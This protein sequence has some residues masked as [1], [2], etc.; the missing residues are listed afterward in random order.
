MLSGSSGI[1]PAIKSLQPSTQKGAMPIAPE[2]IAAQ[3]EVET[4]SSPDIKKKEVYRRLI[5]SEDISKHLLLLNKPINMKNRQILMTMLQHGVQASP[6]NFDKIENM[7]KN[8]KEGNYIESSVIA[9]SKGFGGNS[10][11]IELISGFLS[12]KNMMF[13]SF[14]KAETG[15]KNLLL[16]LN[17]HKGTDPA[18]LLFAFA[19]V[20][21][22]VLIEFK[23]F[24]EMIEKRKTQK[25]LAKSKEFINDLKFYNEFVSGLQYKL[26]GQDSIDSQSKSLLNHL[27]SIKKSFSEFYNSLLTPSVVSKTPDYFDVNQELFHYWMIPNPYVKGNKDFELLISKDKQNNKK[28]NEKKATILIKC[29]TGDMG[30][31]TIHVTVDEKKCFYKFYSKNEKVRSF[32]LDHTGDLKKSMESINFQLTG[33]QVLK[34]EDVLKKLIFPIFNIDEITRISTEA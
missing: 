12:H 22:D 24:K 31:L 27:K 9:F 1:D 13:Q 4:V 10:R 11:G 30:E 25:V 32:V 8:K 6:E 16:F 14:L 18:S 3:Q 33:M 29:E 2:Q 19:A 20:S 17:T 5:N 28:F 15:L 7:I 23:K 26:E 34:K 21:H